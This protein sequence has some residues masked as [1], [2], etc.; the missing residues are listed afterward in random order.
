MSTLQE[1]LTAPLQKKD[2][3]CDPLQTVLSNVQGN[4]LQSHGRNF[5]AHIFL[6]FQAGKQTAV[7]AW[8]RDYIARH[9]TSA[10]KQCVVM[11]AQDQLRERNLYPKSQDRPALF[12][13]CLLSA[14]GYAY[15]GWPTTQFSEAFRSG[16]KP[17]ATARLH[18]IPLTVWEDHYQQP[19]HT[20]II[21]AH[22]DPNVLQGEKRTLVTQ[23]EK[24]GT[25]CWVEDGHVL[26][27][28][29]GM[30]M[31]HFGFVDGHSQPLFF[32]QDLSKE[33]EERGIDLWNPSAGPCLVL[34]L[35]PLGRETDYGSYLVFRKLEQDVDGFTDQLREL[36]KALQKDEEDAAAFV[37]GRYRNGQPLVPHTT[38][39]A[40]SGLNKPVIPNNFR[41]D[42]DWNG[43]RCPFHAHIRRMNPRW[44]TNTAE[45][46]RRI[47]RRSIS[48]GA[49]GDKS[50]GL[51]FMCYQ[52]S[53]EHQFEALQGE[54]AH[55]PK[56]LPPSGYDGLIGRKLVSSSTGGPQWHIE[57]CTTEAFIGSCVTLQ[58]GE[59]FFAP[60]LSF[61][62]SRL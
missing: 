16:M 53:L 43:R 31:D 28:T 38:P 10:Q 30:R 14:S 13:S 29:K 5:A 49:R 1:I 15:L 62:R 6:R 52:Q 22:R 44:E 4:I 40:P 20:L 2:L 21:L 35:D 11:S 27:D 61:L 12:V 50:V 25:Y 19:I 42:M 3:Q 39:Q 57:V 41:Y 23:V 9:L 17:R 18:D 34:T 55:T 37:L 32:Q 51:L 46:D 59:Y 56:G 45:Y 58:G 60:S 7:K 33:K 36:A 47:A 54:W 26:R 8:L 48:Y 24:F